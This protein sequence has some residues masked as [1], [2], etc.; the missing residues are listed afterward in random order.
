[1]NR[2]IPGTNSVKNRVTNS[3]QIVGILLAAWLLTL[4]LACTTASSPSE[5]SGPPPT[6]AEEGRTATQPSGSAETAP[7]GEDSGSTASTTAIGSNEATSGGSTAST[8]PNVPPATTDPGTGSSQEAAGS[9]ST[10]ETSSTSSGRRPAPGG[11]ASAES[12]VEPSAPTTDT[13]TEIISAALP[14]NTVGI[15]LTVSGGSSTGTLKTLVRDPGTGEA[16]GT[17]FIN[18]ESK[19][20]SLVLYLP[21]TGD[22]TVIDTYSSPSYAPHVKRPYTI[23]DRLFISDKYTNGG[24]LSLT[25]YDPQTL[26]RLS[27]WQTQND[28]DDPNYALVDDQVFYRTNTEEHVRFTGTTITGGEIIRSPLSDRSEQA[29]LTERKPYFDLLASQGNLYGSTSPTDWDPLTGVFTVDETTGLAGDYL[30]AFEVDNLASYLP[31]S[32]REPVVDNGTAYWAAARQAAGGPVMEV[33]SYDLSL[34][35]GGVVG[36]SFQ[37]S[38]DNGNIVSLSGIDADS[39][40]VLVS[41]TFEGGDYS[42]VFIYD[43]HDGSAN[44][45]D[46]GFK[47]IDAEVLYLD[48]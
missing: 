30:V 8:A 1:M 23:D 33:W 7:P 13:E 29:V 47:I 19:S 5:P 10:T 18:L 26:N 43:G 34:E 44:V 17:K 48:E 14:V 32:W 46:T 25:E 11:D 20:R 4:V 9:N 6:A 15:V 12:R 35:S 40:L 2:T 28:V 39:G 37:L 22:A 24:S 27:S 31:G 42:K 45:F 21:A 41:P 36:N 16:L 38:P 3:K